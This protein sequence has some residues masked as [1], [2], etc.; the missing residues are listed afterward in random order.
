MYDWYI[1]LGYSYLKKDK[2]KQFVWLIKLVT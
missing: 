1:K 2:N